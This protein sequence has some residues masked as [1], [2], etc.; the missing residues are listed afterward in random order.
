[1]ALDAFIFDVDGTL[2]D[3]NGWHIEAWRRAFE[4]CGYSIA[5]DRIEREIGKGSDKVVDAVL[6]ASGEKEHGEALREAHSEAFL[7]LAEQEQFKV[8]PQTREL[9]Q[10]LRERGLKTALATSSNEVHLDAVQKSAGIELPPL[11]DL[12]TTKDDAANSKPDPD[13]V[14]AAVKKLGLSAAQ[15]AMLGDTPYDAQACKQAGVV[16]IGVLTGGHTPETLISAGARAVY[17]DTAD[18]LQHLDEVLQIA[19][20]SQVP[21]TCEL[22][23]KLMR[24]AL[25]V[26]RE[27]MQNGEA[28][29][30]A[31]LARGDGEIV[32]CGYNE[33]NASQNKTAHAE[34]VTFARAAGKVPLEARDLI[35]VS[36]LEPCV[37]CTGA[38]MEA[39]VDTIVYALRAPADNGSTRVQPPHSP[40]SQMPRIVGNVLAQESRAL[41]EEWLQANDDTR[42]A[43][44][45]K[46]LLALT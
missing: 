25:A 23:E 29:I 35:L 27:G 26:A 16:C 45:V 34:I 4:S 31:V 33:M 8:F 3:T 1:M 20:P 36:T 14:L 10:A 7:Q 37:M 13:L 24:Q 5:P 17:R 39:A 40:E 44:F 41:F 28:P 9:L 43:G 18:V 38:A 32:A 42:Q 6:G 12:I 11:V 46:Q 2:L 22:Q 19:S 21:L 30:G 15:C